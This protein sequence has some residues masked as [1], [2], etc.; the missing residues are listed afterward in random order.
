MKIPEMVEV[1][2]EKFNDF[3]KKYPEK[4]EKDINYTGEP[5]M[6]TY[7][8]FS[9]EKEWPESIVASISLGE[10]YKDRYPDSKNRYFILKN[11]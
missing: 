3:I 11:G 8:D 5:E 7:N 2:K 10:R 9:G 4:L 1:D 6:L